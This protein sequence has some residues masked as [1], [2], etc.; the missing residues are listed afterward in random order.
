MFLVK[1]MHYLSNNN[2][3]A[4]V[5]EAASESRVFDSKKALSLAHSTNGKL[6]PIRI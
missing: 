6:T 2:G 3:E 1:R 4:V 5:V